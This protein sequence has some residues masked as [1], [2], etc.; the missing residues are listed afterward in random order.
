M[1]IRL[2][3]SWVDGAHGTGPLYRRI[4]GQIRAAVRSGELAGGDR[5][6]PIRALA[7]QLGVNRD[8]VADAYGVL[9][10][11]GLIESAAGRGTFVR[12]PVQAPAPPPPAIPFSPTV[13]RLLDFEHARPPL[14]APPGVAPLHSLTPD[15]SL[16]PMRAFRRALDRVL[17]ESGTELLVYGPSRGNDPL[18][19]AIAGHL[20]GHGIGADPDEVVLCQ[21]AS[22]GISLALRLYAEPGDSVAVEEPTYHNVLAAIT[23]LGLRPVPVPMRADGPDLEVLEGVL[24]RPEVKLLYTMPSFHNPMGTTTSLA[25]R[26]ALLGI[27]RRLGKPVIEDGFELDLRY[28]G[29]PVAPLAAL[30][31][32]GTVVHLF[33]FSKSLFPGLRVGAITARG[34]AIGGLLALKQASDLSGALLLQAAVA[35]FVRCGAYRRHLA[36]LR[37][38]LRARC[39]TLLAALARHLP[40]G[41]RWTEPE[42]GYQVWVELPE[43]LDSRA[44]L[45]VAHQAGVAYAPG[46]QFHHDGRPSRALRLTT[47]LA[48]CAAIERGVAALGEALRRE[49]ARR[50]SEASRGASINV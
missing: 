30:D 16:Y 8:T 18:R 42:G 10:R 32:G 26:H 33:S 9:A 2:D 1:D 11:E 47:A 22:Q 28:R 3:S 23:G 4:A 40:E 48:D 13:E 14:E 25:H 7:A 34:R 19:A 50:R 49:L 46:Y 5:L 31:H 39:R 24:S 20:A 12:G 45:P 27:A 35:E 17:G 36:S 29:R 41:S 44:L 6:P 38:T 43:G 21:G 37:R 15:P